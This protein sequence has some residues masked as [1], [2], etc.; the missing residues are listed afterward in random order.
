[1]ASRIAARTGAAEVDGADSRRAARAFHAARL[2]IPGPA[3]PG[4]VQAAGIV[5]RKRIFR[6][7]SPAFAAADRTQA[8]DRDRTPQG[9]IL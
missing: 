9:R 8:C 3:D 5:A 7:G 2:T 4:F 1:M 6:I